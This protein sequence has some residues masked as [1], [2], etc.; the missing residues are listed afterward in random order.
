MP[1]RRVSLSPSYFGFLY[2]P[3]LWYIDWGRPRAIFHLVVVPSQNSHLGLHSYNGSSLSVVSQRNT[4]AIPSLRLY[5]AEILITFRTAAHQLR[6]DTRQKTQS[7][8]IR[9]TSAWLL[10]PVCGGFHN[11]IR[12]NCAPFFAWCRRHRVLTHA[13]VRATQGEQHEVASRWK[14]N[15]NWIE[16]RDVMEWRNWLHGDLRDLSCYLNYYVSSESSKHPVGT[17]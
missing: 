12:F 13:G 4:R 5:T 14:I 3:V 1:F 9:D 8:F 15:V 16:S 17:W 7:C 6:Q 2:C 10:R 11:L